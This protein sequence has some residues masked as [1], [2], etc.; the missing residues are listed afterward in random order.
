MT[1]LEHYN[2]YYNI[3]KISITSNTRIWNDIII[4]IHLFCDNT[5]MKA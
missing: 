3:I 5:V 1:R 4:P 2:S